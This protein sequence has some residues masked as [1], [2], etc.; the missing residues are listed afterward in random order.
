MK[1]RFLSIVF[2]ISADAISNIPGRKPRSTASQ[3]T[4]ETTRKAIGELRRQ[5]YSR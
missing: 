3:D 1:F 4:E 2:E 5:G